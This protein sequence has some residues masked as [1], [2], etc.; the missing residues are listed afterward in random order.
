MVTGPWG[1][2]QQQ[3]GIQTTRA[4]P[5]KRLAVKTSNPAR[6]KVPTRGARTAALASAP[7]THLRTETSRAERVQALTR[8]DSQKGGGQPQ[9]LQDSS[10]RIKPSGR[11]MVVEK[12]QSLWCRPPGRSTSDFSRPVQAFWPPVFWWN[13]CVTN[14]QLSNGWKRPAGQPLYWRHTFT[15]HTKETRNHHI[16]NQSRNQCFGFPLLFYYTGKWSAHFL[17]WT[18][19]KQ[20]H[21]HLLP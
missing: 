2:Q 5:E 14:V 19:I 11:G 6:G 9:N 21:D 1:P 18:A 7:A 12:H 3:A 20:Q 16:S 13:K 17:V 8:A 15:L 4:A 10:E